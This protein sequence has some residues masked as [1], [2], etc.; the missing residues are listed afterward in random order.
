VAEPDSEPE[1]SEAH[2]GERHHDPGDQDHHHH[3]R[4]APA[5]IVFSETKSFG[6]MPL[7]LFALARNSGLN[8]RKEFAKPI[9]TLQAAILL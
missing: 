8:T 6:S 4:S 9:G 7:T 3:K 5:K 1:Q 2:F